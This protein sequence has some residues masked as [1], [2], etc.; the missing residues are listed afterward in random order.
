MDD[1]NLKK[2]K[3][4]VCILVVF[5]VVIMF[6]L[7]FIIR[8]GENLSNEEENLTEMSQEEYVE[9]FE[10]EGDYTF[11]RNQNAEISRDDYAGLQNCVKQYLEVINVNNSVYYGYNEEGNY[12]RVIDNKT[13]SNRI[14][15]LLSK[16]YIEKNSIEKDYAI[17]NVNVLNE[18]FLYSI[19]EAEKLNTDVV[20]SFAAHVLVQAMDDYSLL[21]NIYIIVN[22]DEDNMTFSVE[23]LENRD[24]IEEFK[25]KESLQIVELNEDNTFQYNVLSD[26][27]MIRNYINIY[28]RVSMI[29]P[30]Y[31]YSKLDSEYREKRFPTLESFEKFI[32]ENRERIEGLNISEYMKNEKKEYTQYVCLDMNGKYIFINETSSM[33]Y[34]LILD[35]YT[36]DSDEFIAKYDKS[37]E[38]VKVGMNIVKVFEAIN[39]FDYGY[40]YNKL[41]E[42]FKKN[43]YDTIEKFIKYMKE[44]LYENNEVEYVKCS[45]EQNTYIY[46]IKVTDAENESSLE[47]NMTI[48]MQLLDDRDFVMS[49]SIE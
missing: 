46:Q 26:Q 39:G 42:T 20:K 21:Q 6:W 38:E 40:V 12:V 9:I 13:I 28:K 19:V 17:G 4:I 23:P 36:I 29:Y 24:A 10:E 15:N 25:Q 48:I 45:K 11:S 43:N 33:E 3:I 44:N 49:F 2:I 5:I 1:K 7:L 47:K 34:T 27:D 18:L 31:I 22:M 32:T 30:N 14:Y 41:D 8:K 35:D 16:D 37:S